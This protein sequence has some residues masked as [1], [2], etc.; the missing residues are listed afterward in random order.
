MQLVPVTLTRVFDIK[1]AGRRIA[2]TNFFFESPERGV[3]NVDV[4]G[5][6]QLKSGMKLLFLLQDENDF[7]KILGFANLRNNEIYVRVPPSRVFFDLIMY[8]GVLPSMFMWHKTPVVWKP[9]IDIAAP[10]YLLGVPW[11][12][13]GLIKSLKAKKTLKKALLTER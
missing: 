9:F 5:K 13:Y 8:I 3:C 7:S 10:Y 2:R 11:L 1:I 12:T 6:P 4:S